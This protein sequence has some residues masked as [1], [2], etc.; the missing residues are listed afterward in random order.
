M[1]AMKDEAYNDFVCIESA[2]AFDDFRLVE[3]GKTHTLK[4]TIY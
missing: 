1:S 4:A 2:N 3:P